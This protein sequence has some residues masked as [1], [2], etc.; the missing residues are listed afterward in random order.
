MHGGVPA[1][2]RPSTGP[3]Y[4]DRSGNSFLAWS[5]VCVWCVWGGGGQPRQPLRQSVCTTQSYPIDSERVV[6]DLSLIASRFP[7]GAGSVG[8]RSVSSPLDQRSDDRRYQERESERARDQEIKRSRDQETKRPRETK[9][10]RSRDQETKREEQRKLPLMSLPSDHRGISGIWR[11][12]RLILDNCLTT[13]VNSGDAQQR[14]P[15]HR[16]IGTGMTAFRPA[17]GA[18]Q[19]EHGGR[20]VG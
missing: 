3:R 10:E 20:P 16:Q 17:R 11:S 13:A 15:R 19:G 2:V 9:R 1:R 12:V 14:H 4:S 5:V 8:A 18:I 6:L 7:A